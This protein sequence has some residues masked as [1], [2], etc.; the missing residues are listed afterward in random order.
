MTTKLIFLDDM[1]S[2]PSEEWELA[3]DPFKAYESILNAHDAGQA[4]IIS[5]DHDLGENI[6]TGYD[7]LNWLE[8]DIATQ[9]NFLPDISFRI[10]SGNPVGCTNMERAIQAIE[11]RLL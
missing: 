11:R 7:L 1:R 8:R 6:P 4:I 10:H 3:R 9:D 5:L 2:P